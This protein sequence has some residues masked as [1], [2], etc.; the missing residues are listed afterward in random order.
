[1]S[2]D[3]DQPEVP[4]VPRTRAE[5][6][7]AREAA[8]AASADSAEADIDSAGERGAESA[9]EPVADPAAEREA[10]MRAAMVEAAAA[11]EAA[12][13]EAAA[14]APDLTPR[15]A[16]S[17]ISDPFRAPDEAA[18]RS[19]SEERSDETKRVPPASTSAD[20]V[21][22]RSARSTTR[23]GDGGVSS[24]SA[25]STTERPSEA[26]PRT[27][28]R[29]FLLAL[30]AVLGVLVVV[31]AGLGFVSLTQGPRITNVQVAPDEAIESS[32]SR[33]ILTANQAL[34]AIDASQV[35]VEPAVPVKVDA[36]GRRNG[37]RFT[38]PLDDA[39]KNNITVADLT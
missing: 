21:S 23:D 31:G 35:S 17:T 39:T 32:G 13:R 27:P 22:S 14:P 12:A 3:D 1:M 25:R 8:A 20:G 26:A 37:I 11:A 28:S 34:S 36:A 7:A 24:R 5:L 4:V 10:A 18:P 19:L 16:R 6:R 30:T 15:S 2:T 9:A 38:L 29:R 33:V